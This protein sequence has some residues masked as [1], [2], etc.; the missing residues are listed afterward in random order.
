[1]AS[2]T[3]GLLLP[4]LLVLPPP[5]SA[6]ASIYWTSNPVLPGNE[7]LV[8]AG[9]GLGGAGQVAV[10]FCGDAACASPTRANA[11]VWESSLQVLLPGGCG[12]PCT[13]RLPATIAGVGVGGAAAVTVRVNA[14][15]VAWSPNRTAV[16]GELRAFGRGLAW[17]AD[18]A[19]CL[20]ASPTPAAVTTTTLSIDGRRVGTASAASCYEAAFRLPPSVQPGW[21]T[22]TVGTQW[23]SSAAF[24]VF[25]RPEPEAVAHTIEVEGDVR[26]ALLAAAQLSG[27]VVV[28]LGPKRYTLSHHLAIPNRT[29]LVGAG[30][31]T[32][33]DF[34]LPP[35]ARPSCAD[36]HMAAV[37][38][39]GDDWGLANLSLVLT[40]SP[41]ETALIWAAPSSTRARLVHLNISLLQSN[42]SNNALFFQ[43][44]GFE[45]GHSS[46][47]QHGACWFGGPNVDMWDQAGGRQWGGIHKTTM[48]AEGA[49]EGWIHHN[50][51]RSPNIVHMVLAHSIPFTAADQLE[52][53]RLG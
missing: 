6:P 1:M 14:P 28:R 13:L 38:G 19:A 2:G 18:L 3:R 30:P 9:A 8:V 12:P 33:L 20:S 48:A 23:G 47:T 44:H 11:T 16:G 26:S 21:H 40:E 15:E 17:S 46:V 36:C 22:A 45:F 25:V 7:T 5:V 52:L 41:P 51:V 42:I 27:R 37:L 43:G 39:V 10:Q 49:S 35:S 31:A 32:T 4:L 24:E 53:R 50:H 29:T 34:S